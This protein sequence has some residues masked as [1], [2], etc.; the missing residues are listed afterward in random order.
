ML[1][2][3]YQTQAHVYDLICKECR[4]IPWADWLPSWVYDKFDECTCLACPEC[5]GPS[6]DRVVTGM[7]C[8]L[9][10]YGP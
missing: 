3:I 8:G 10:A 7:K 6:D 5:G 1:G 9:C 4:G 2:D